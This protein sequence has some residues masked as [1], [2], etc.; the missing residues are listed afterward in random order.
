[1]K[2][3]NSSSLNIAGKIKDYLKLIKVSLSIMVVFSTVLPY[4][5]VPGIEGKYVDP[6]KMTK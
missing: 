1:M 4:L 2:S 3:D 5:L 6:L